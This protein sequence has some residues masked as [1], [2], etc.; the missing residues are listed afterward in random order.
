MTAKKILIFS[1]TSCAISA[2]K[3]RKTIPIAEIVPN[4]TKLFKVAITKTLKHK[5][6]SNLTKTSVALEICGVPFDYYLS[7]YKT[8]QIRPTSIASKYSLKSDNCI[9]VQV[10]LLNGSL[11]N[12]SWLADILLPVQWIIEF[13]ISNHSEFVILFHDIETR[14]FL[15]FTTYWLEAINSVTLVRPRMT[16]R[17][18]QNLFLKICKPMQKRA[19][20]VITSPQFPQQRQE[21]FVAHA[22]AR[23]SVGGGH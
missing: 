14:V 8:Q 11:D 23:G 4:K 2:Q 6:E 1:I 18:D 13:C 10:D 20:W 15:H 17:S 22:H 12:T 19:T 7:S 3:L 9:L 21:P 5:K 16:Y